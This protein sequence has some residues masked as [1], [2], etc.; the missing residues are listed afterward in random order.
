M[1]T[2]EKYNVTTTS[3]IL[4]WVSGFSE[5]EDEG[6]R[7]TSPLPLQRPDTQVTSI[8]SREGES[9]GL[10]LCPFLICKKLLPLVLTLEENH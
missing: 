4:A 6:V 2:K 7:G 10:P 9:G 5:W 8:P 1:R 3:P